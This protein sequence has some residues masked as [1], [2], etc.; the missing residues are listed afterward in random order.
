MRILILGGTAEARELADRLVSLGHDVTTS[1]AGRT[2]HP[3]LPA[4]ALR[5]GKF[6]G[7]PGLAGYLT[8]VA[9]DRLV[10]ATHPY[11]GLI[12]VNAVAAAAQTHTRL[13]RFMREPWREPRGADWIHVPNT[14]AAAVSLPRGAHVLVTT[15]HEGLGALL[16]RRDCTF[17]VRLIEPP[18]EP[19]PPHA[20]LLLARP[21]YNLDGERDLLVREGIGALVSK[22]SGGDH[23]SAKLEAARQLGIPVVMIDRPLY[24]P[25][26]EVGTIDD[27]IEALH[28]GT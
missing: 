8:A 15:G 10:D 27:A 6:G 3:A 28:L 1:L 24:G 14:G 4:G 7:V 18:A 12:S 5:V 13:V 17:L 2:S 20:Q 26:I 22:N 9:V 11:A 19:L 25:A 23:T 16:E 21:P